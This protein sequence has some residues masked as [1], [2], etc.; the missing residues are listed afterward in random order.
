[1]SC[2]P[3]K[4]S[5]DDRKADA[6]AGQKMGPVGEL[7]DSKRSDAEITLHDRTQGPPKKTGKK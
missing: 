2:D 5:A 1:L 7:P 3:R 4:D 6:L